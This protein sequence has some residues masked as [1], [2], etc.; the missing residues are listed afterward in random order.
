MLPRVL[1][2]IRMTSHSLILPTWR[3]EDQLFT[4]MT[5]ITVIHRKEGNKKK[6]RERQK[7]TNH[8]FIP[9]PPEEHADSSST[10]GSVGGAGSHII[11]VQ[12]SLTADALRAQHHPTEQAQGGVLPVVISRL[13]TPEGRKK[14]T[15]KLN[16]YSRS[17]NQRR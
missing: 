13:G 16:I 5:R 17:S 8:A 10:G 11:P 9:N 6:L 3:N 7:L 15:K 14:Q 2:A 12:L 1:L 4:D